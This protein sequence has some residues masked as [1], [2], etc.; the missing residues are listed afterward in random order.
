[1]SARD[2]I[3]RGTTAP[4]AISQWVRSMALHTEQATGTLGRTRFRVLGNV[5]GIDPIIAVKAPGDTSETWYSIDLRTVVAAVLQIHKKVP[6]ANRGMFP[7]DVPEEGE[8][9]RG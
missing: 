8:K 5:V 4:L 3:E 2:R 7:A 1:V 9:A 6:R